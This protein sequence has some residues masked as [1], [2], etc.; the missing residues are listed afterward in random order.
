MDNSNNK[1]VVEVEDLKQSFIKTAD[2]LV[3]D[4]KRQEKIMAR[5]DK[6]QRQEY[7]ELQSRLEE[8]QKLQLAQKELMDSFIKLIA[9]AI[10]AKSR[11]TGGHCKR[12]PELSMMLAQAASKSEEGIFK[13]FK[14]ET[15]DELR[16]LDIAS[17]LHDCGKVTTPEYVVDK[18]TKLETIY[19]R[20][21]EVR[22]RFEV[23][24]RDLT[25][26]ALN[27]KLEGQDEKEVEKWLENEHKKLFEEFELVAV[28]NVGAEFTDA[29]T[30][31]R[32]KDIA[33]EPG[34]EILMIHWD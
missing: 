31:E 15:E 17:W 28:S 13:D 21:H 29:Q 30:Q 20:I 6:R 23:I 34:L 12:V 10:D 27:K 25:I 16:E 2:K 3:K 26:E 5:S 8:V 4:I 24:H 11:Y 9:G 32:I 22:T 33:K 7:D 1:L 14:L 18:A 19:N